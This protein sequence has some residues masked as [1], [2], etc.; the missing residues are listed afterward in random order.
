MTPPSNPETGGIHVKITLDD[1]YR[2]LIELKRSVNDVPAD[3]QDHESRI[4]T[5]EK[6]VWSAAGISGIL[7]GALVA[8][9]QGLLR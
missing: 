1:I 7:S 6:V 5:L 3:V 9:I 2:E 8:I 4:R